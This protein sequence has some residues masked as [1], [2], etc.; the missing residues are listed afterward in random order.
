MRTI[1]VK[2]YLCYGVCL[3]GER[4]G[5]IMHV[6]RKKR[7]KGLCGGFWLVKWISGLRYISL[8]FVS[9]LSENGH[10]DRFCGPIRV[11]IGLQK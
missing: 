9:N 10:L 5:G 4:G 2:S 7:E 8:I 3:R 6:K 11:H 1:H